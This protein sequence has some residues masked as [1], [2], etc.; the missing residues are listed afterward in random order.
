MVR[1]GALCAVLGWLL[2]GPAL[3][4]FQTVNDGDFVALHGRLV[5]ATGETEGRT[6]KYIA[7]E[8]ATPIDFAC[9]SDDDPC[10]PE[11]GQSLLQLAIME[12]G[13][14]ARFEDNLG[15]PA[16]VSGEL[17][18]SHTIH[19]HTRVLVS[20]ESI[21]PL[22]MLSVPFEDGRYVNDQRLCTF[23]AQEPVLDQ[24][25]SLSAHAGSALIEGNEFSCRVTEAI[26]T[27]GG[28]SL[29]GDCWSEGEQYQA[30]Y[31]LGAFVGLSF[32]LN[33]IDMQR[34][35][36]PPLIL[37]IMA[38]YP[39]PPPAPSTEHKELAI[40]LRP[41]HASRLGYGSRVGMEV[42][43]IAVSGQGTANAS[44]TSEHTAQNAYDFCA[45]YA[46]NP[47][48][49]CILGVLEENLQETI[50]AD[51][52]A[53]TFSDFWGDRY[54][55]DGVAPQEHYVDY[56]IVD[57]ASGEV[58]DGSG[59]S[60]YT[61]TLE[62]YQAL[63]APDQLSRP[64]ISAQTY[65]AEFNRLN[66]WRGESLLHR[67]G[68]SELPII[69]FAMAAR[70]EEGKRLRLK[71]SDTILT[72]HGHFGFA[73]RDGASLLVDF[74]RR[75]IMACLY[76]TP[77]GKD[78]VSS[79]FGTIL[80]SGLDGFDVPC[81][82]SVEEALEEYF[83]LIDENQSLHVSTLDADGF[84]T[85]ESVDH[86]KDLLGL[87]KVI[88]FDACKPELEFAP[89]WFSVFGA[90]FTGEG[91]FEG[92]GL[93]CHIVDSRYVREEDAI[94]VERICAGAGYSSGRSDMSVARTPLGGFT[95][96][97][98]PVSQ[99]ASHYFA[100]RERYGI[101]DAAAPMVRVAA[102]KAEDAE[103]WT[104]GD[105][106]LF[107][108]GDVEASILLEPG[109]Y[110]E[111]PTV[112]LT[113]SRGGKPLFT[114]SLPASESGRGGIGV[115]PMG[116]SGE[117]YLLFAS[118]T[119][120]ASCCTEFTAL[121]IDLAR[122][123][124]RSL[125]AFYGDVWAPQDIDR[126]GRY[127]LLLEDHRFNYL[128]GGPPLSFRPPV[129]LGERGGQLVD[130]T[131]D[132]KFRHAVGDYIDIMSLSCGGYQG[133]SMSACLGWAA[134]ASKLGGY[135]EA[136]ASIRGRMARS[137]LPQGWQGGEDFG[138]T[139][140]LIEAKLIELGYLVRVLGKGTD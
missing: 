90:N 94:A 121:P 118:F 84:E 59:A 127:E 130:V 62:I 99:C 40:D 138:S 16:Q 78:P 26:K 112:T 101:K 41:P 63:C 2:A 86:Y 11:H 119:G 12:D 139:A 56:S 5:E 131:N 128:Y 73:Q 51:C 35:D 96:D 38:T 132:P 9:A 66:G 39:E 67:G 129:I 57:L 72:M 136:M 92:G 21:E 3:A 110:D 69:Q 126:D 10:E 34:C 47:S 88:Y 81:P 32:T 104:G 8:L 33:G 115:F 43:V 74:G 31:E 105:P 18:H 76:D 75:D 89:E 7:L 70:P 29:S 71:L 19:H 114:T 134:T 60:G 137:Q 68:I 24:A 23:L 58:L 6:V 52:H 46:G 140:T 15:K 83:P 45:L 25:I 1:W 64:L 120:G 135:D 54:R 124:A 109:D 37:D 113:G 85:W 107:R 36:A 108:F 95:F 93:N 125:G 91:H 87:G 100:V 50:A 14:W 49:S 106:A 116:P 22:P 48:A 44:I 28:Y 4:Q 27:R 79:R 61:T 82:S 20:V 111:H 98:N 30:A 122:P 13:D 17:Y 80:P 103:E 133:W 123:R 65:P 117:L 53:G 97:G 102:I 55:F 42:D 77:R